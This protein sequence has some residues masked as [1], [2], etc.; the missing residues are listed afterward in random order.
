[1]IKLILRSV[2]QFVNSQTIGGVL[3]ALAA[4]AG[5]VLS[6][7][8]WQSAYQAF[9]QMTTELRI[10][11]DWLVL[12][13][14]TIIWVNDLW[15]AVFF[16]L[17]G[18]E[19]KRELLEGEL[20]SV[21]QALLP[22]GAAIGG[23]LVPALIYMLINSHD[24]L[25]MRGWGIP[26]ATDIAFALGILVLLGDRVPVSLKIFLTAVAIIDDLGAILVIAFFY[27]A[28]LSLTMLA[29]AGGGFLALLVMNRA[30]VTA[31]GPYVI[32]GLVIWVCV[33]KSG[34]HATLA[35]VITALAVPM[36]DGQGGSPLGRAEHALHPW[37]AYL[38]LPVFA[39]ANAG[40][41][42]DGVSVA[43]LLQTVPLGIAVG[44]VVGKATGV[45][46][47]SWL[48]IQFGGARLPEH[49]NWM[50]FFGVCV[51]C[52]VG[53]TM[54]LFI[55]S[56]AFE[57]AGPDYATQVKIG[58]LTGSLVSAVLAVILLIK[59]GPTEG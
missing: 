43:T 13:K 17:V 7:S 45:F 35:G 25:A 54:S 20:A 44:L 16:F 30:R 15:M 34:I 3:L 32:V 38:I 55:G 22:A 51:L 4:M 2:N 26:M 5:L 10:G 11:G 48:L 49:C 8:P 36:K 23:M 9:L 58:V 29:S 6:N 57:G 14:P 37:V 21:R 28:D 39:F 46:G 18:L 47:A 52:G 1:M 56:L 59:R 42:L 50:Q 40:V 19:I 24:P 27:T 53:F 33:L 12:S 41:S 31:I